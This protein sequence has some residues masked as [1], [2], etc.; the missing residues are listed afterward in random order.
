MRIQRRFATIPT[1]SSNKAWRHLFL[2]LKFTYLSKTSRAVFV[3]CDEKHSHRVWVWKRNKWPGR[4][5]GGGETFG[6]VANYWWSLSSLSVGNQRL[7]KSHRCEVGENWYSS[8][9]VAVLGSLRRRLFTIFLSFVNNTYLPSR[10]RW[11]LYSNP[12]IPHSVEKILHLA[13]W[14]LG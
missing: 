2:R 10:L 11:N 14:Q 6:D 13:N 5:P 1:V 8:T 12:W 7:E 4:V 9:Q 3:T